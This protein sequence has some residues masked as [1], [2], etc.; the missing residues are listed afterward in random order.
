M[1]INKRQDTKPSKNKLSFAF[2]KEREGEWE[3]KTFLLK[4]H[5]QEKLIHW[6]FYACFCCGLRPPEMFF[7]AATTANRTCT[8][9]ENTFLTLIV[10]KVYVDLNYFCRLWSDPSFMPSIM[11]YQVFMMCGRAKREM[12]KMARKSEAHDSNSTCESDIKVLKK[13]LSFRTDK[14]DYIY[15][16]AKK[17]SL[18]Y[19]RV[20]FP[21][22]SFQRHRYEIKNADTWKSNCNKN[23]KR[24]KI[25]Y[26]VTN[27]E[28]IHMRFDFTNEIC[29]RVWLLRWMWKLR[30]MRFRCIASESEKF[31]AIIRQPWQQLRTSN[32]T[33]TTR[34]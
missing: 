19:P 26:K 18:N 5:F 24:E 15:G 21:G 33:P 29:S 11:R 32:H 1:W 3:E 4:I 22:L 23:W 17:S 20:P 27:H 28:R 7:C 8:F 34:Q 9:A 2:A 10:G 16:S 30:Q 12:N 14:S 25:P 6:F 13:A 31:D